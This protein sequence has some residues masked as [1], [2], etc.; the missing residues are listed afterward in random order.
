MGIE[1]LFIELLIL[2]M[3]MGTFFDHES[4][5]IYEIDENMNTKKTDY[6]A[7]FEKNPTYE[8]G[9]RYCF[10]G[11]IKNKYGQDSTP[12]MFPTGKCAVKVFK[13]GRAYD[14]FDIQNDLN[15]TK[16][17]Q[18]VSEIFNSGNYINKKLFFTNIYL[19]S[20]EKSAIF[21]FFEKRTFNKNEYLIIEPHIDGKYEKFVSNSGWTKGNIGITIPLFMHWNWV[22]S[23]GQKLV[24]D[25]QGVKKEYIYE[26]TDPAVQSINQE[27][28]NTDLGIIGLIYFLITHK[29]NKYCRSLPW[30][31]YLEIIEIEDAL[32]ELSMM[33]KKTTYGSKYD[34]NKEIEELYLKIIDSTF[35][36]DSNAHDNIIIFLI[37]FIFVISLIIR[38]NIKKKIG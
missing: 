16:Y 33:E 17:S 26:L 9:S 2:S 31:S 35:N 19:T 21:N 11:N 7:V 20:F 6:Y 32:K 28:G 4:N 3:G 23:K 27:Y 15:N 18:K 25:I 10:I 8:G 5:Y 1:S 14:Y 29:H 12:N 34:K 22:Y 13:D 38:I 24:T 36:N 30:P 37:I